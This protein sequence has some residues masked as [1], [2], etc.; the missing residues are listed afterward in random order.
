MLTAPADDSTT[1]VVA[2]QSWGGGGTV[3]WS[4]SLQTQGYVRKAWADGGLP[5]FTSAAFQS[6]LDRVCDVMGVSTKFIKHN[7]QNLHLMEGARKLGWAHKEVPQNTGGSEHSCGHCTLGCGACEKQGPA[8]AWLPAA[9]KKGAKFIEGFDVRTILFEERQGEKVAVGVRGIWCSRDSNGGTAGERL[10]TRELIVKAKRVIVSC[11]TMQSPLLLMR[12]GLKNYHIGRN[13]YLH[14]V[15]L[16][17]AVWDEVTNP[18]NGPIL[19]SAVTEFENLDGKGH[20]VKLE[21][22]NMLPSSWLIWPQWRGG[23]EYKRFASKMKHMGGYISVPRDRDTGRVYP[24]PDDGR[25]RVQYHPSAFDKKNIMEG[26][27]ALAKICYVQGARE[28]FTVVPGVPSFIRSDNPPSPSTASS[29]NPAE[30][31]EQGINDP[32]FNTWL[33]SVRRNG[34]PYPETVF[35]AAHQMG[36]CR[37]AASSKS[38]VVDPSGRVWGCQNLFVAD[39][40]VFPTAS[41][42]NPMVTTMAISDFISKGVVRGLESEK[43]SAAGEASARL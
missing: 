15:S 25:V 17:G 7:P 13:L 42:V 27:L 5:F 12:S 26:V 43:R 4:A 36:T 2:G 16:V 30:A 20:G 1:S 8:V 9:A 21:T 28:I 14:P 39:A 23:L 29:A 33:E 31:E 18:W 35:V 3:N 34:F 40:S 10:V 32:L 41:G 6:S 19:T 22:T 24:D 38:G 37:M 11:G